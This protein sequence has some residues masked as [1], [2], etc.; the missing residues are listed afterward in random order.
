MKNIKL[1]ISFYNPILIIQLRRIQFTFTTFSHLKSDFFF[2][3]N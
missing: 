1:Y 2:F 3:L